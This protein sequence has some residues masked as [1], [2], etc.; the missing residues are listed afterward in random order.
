M[1]DAICRFVKQW[2]ESYRGELYLAVPLDR[3]LDLM[4]SY[5]EE[6]GEDGLDV[7]EVTKEDV[8]KCLKNDDTV[9]VVSTK[10]GNEVLWLW[11]G[12]LLKDMIN[13]IAE[14]ADRWGEAAVAAI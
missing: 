5:L 2:I 11:G 7:S 3:L 8:K 10:D 12:R 9:E 4:N 13:K 1:K 14:L 6:L